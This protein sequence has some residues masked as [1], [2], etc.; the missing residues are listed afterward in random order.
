MKCPKCQGECQIIQET[1]TT[2]SDF[3]G[4]KG[5]CGLAC[6]GPLGLLCGGGNKKIKDVSYWVCNECG[7][8]FKV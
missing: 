1:K 8:K 6:F 3:S 2:G 4:T 7:K 5:A